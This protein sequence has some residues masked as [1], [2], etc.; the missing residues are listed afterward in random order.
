MVK[1]DMFTEI[2]INQSIPALYSKLS[3]SGH[4]AML[5]ATAPCTKDAVT[6]KVH[7]LRL[8]PSYIDLHLKNP[9]QFKEIRLK[10]FY[11]GCAI[12]IEEGIDADQ[13]VKGQFGSN[14][15]TI[16]RYVNRLESCFKIRYHLFYGD[17][18]SADYGFIMAALKD[19]IERR[20]HQLNDINPD[21]EFWDEIFE[22]TYD[23]IH[24]K[25]ASLF[26]IY[27]S[28]L[29]I[30]V[31]LN[32]H[33]DRI[34]YSAISSYDIDYSKFGLGHIEIFKQLE[35][36][37][38]NGYKVFEMGQGDLDYKRRWSNGV[39]HFEHRIVYRKNSL[40]QLI[41]SYLELFKVK[42]RA[43]LNSK[44]IQIKGFKLVTYITKRKETVVQM[45]YETEPITAE[46]PFLKIQKIDLKSE[47]Y[48]FLRKM[49]NDYLY[50]QTECYSDIEVFELVPN[51]TYIIKGPKGA[52]RITLNYP[53][54]G[55]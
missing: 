51:S 41:I 21:L 25:T 54:S 47:Q 46:E 38:T 37:R 18:T 7:S 6:T 48:S 14:A 2:F 44:N 29:P 35:W 42:F 11:L 40:W 49:V 32:Y 31:S 1:R 15:K 36:C 5:A 8:L 27:H 55:S 53:P 45:G 13:Y 23:K 17:I 9:V 52:Q 4:T 30:E 22:E 34:L 28:D 3:Y 50:T 20:F 10:Q 16:R 43:Y 33:F 39:Y 19:M 24:Q 26:V 12:H